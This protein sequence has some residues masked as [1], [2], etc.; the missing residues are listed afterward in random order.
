MLRD[1]L[2]RL[3]SR[4]ARKTAL[5]G[6]G[7]LC[8]LAGI[9]FLTLTLWMH[10]ALVYGA[11]A[12]SLTLGVAYLGLGLLLIGLSSAKTAPPTGKPADPGQSGQKAPAPDTSEAPPLVQAFIYGVQAGINARKS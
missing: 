10:L 1:L 6:G 11:I 12:A 9:V 8:V 5:V 3:A 2:Q 7:A 4:A